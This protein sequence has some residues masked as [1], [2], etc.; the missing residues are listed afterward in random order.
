MLFVQTCSNFLFFRL[1][2]IVCSDSPS[3]AIEVMSRD[4]TI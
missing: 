1:L 3:V 4:C 2:H